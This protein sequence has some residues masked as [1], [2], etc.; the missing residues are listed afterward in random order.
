MDSDDNSE[1]DEETGSDEKDEKLET[2][3]FVQKK[4]EKVSKQTDL[5]KRLAVKTWTSNK[6]R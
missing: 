3:R 5:V 4:G 1:N 2:D 6:G